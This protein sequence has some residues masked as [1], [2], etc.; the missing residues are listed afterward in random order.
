VKVERSA[1]CGGAGLLFIF[2]QVSASGAEA[3]G[4]RHL[5]GWL[6]CAAE[7]PGFVTC[8]NGASQP[9]FVGGQINKHPNLGGMNLL[10]GKACEKKETVNTVIVTGVRRADRLGMRHP[11]LPEKPT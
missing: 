11:A 6:T 3:R 9:F 10:I 5:F 7:G 2:T 8:S 4:I 1:A